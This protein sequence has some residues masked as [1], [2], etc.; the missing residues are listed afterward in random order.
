MCFKQFRSVPTVEGDK[1]DYGPACASAS[2][3]INW[4]KNL[5]FSED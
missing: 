4:D 3:F 5:R 2:S 1:G